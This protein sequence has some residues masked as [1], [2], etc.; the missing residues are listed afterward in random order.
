MHGV[1]MGNQKHGV[2]GRH[3]ERK[4]EGAGRGNAGSSG[5]CMEG[6]HNAHAWEHPEDVRGMHGE[7][8]VRKGVD[9]GRGEDG[10]AA[11]GC[12]QFLRGW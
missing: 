2:G 4:M 3:A 8:E 5:W 7:E 11:R 6:S 10:K 9:V 12:M 1:G